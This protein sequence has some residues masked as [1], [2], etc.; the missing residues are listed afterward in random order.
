MVKVIELGKIS[1]EAKCE[2][3]SKIKRLKKRFPK[4]TGNGLEK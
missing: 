2:R 3:R 4:K 1:D